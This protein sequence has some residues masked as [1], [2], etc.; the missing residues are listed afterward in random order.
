MSIPFSLMFYLIARAV[1]SPKALYSALYLV[2]V[3]S[4]LPVDPET[5]DTVKLRFFL[6]FYVISIYL[7]EYD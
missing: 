2:D 4:K 6:H 5:G 7:K 3:M 1:P